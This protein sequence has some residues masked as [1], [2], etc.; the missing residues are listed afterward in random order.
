MGNDIFALKDD[1]SKAKEKAELMAGRT[2][3]FKTTLDPEAWNG[4]RVEFMNETMSVHLNGK[5][6]GQ[7]TS[8]GI[9]HDTKTHIGWTVLG[10]GVH[11]DNFR[12]W[13][14]QGE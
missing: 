10:Q 14:A 11:F 3:S 13:K 4:L 9:A 5:D 8:P 12:I 7:L 6:V 1:P 2:A